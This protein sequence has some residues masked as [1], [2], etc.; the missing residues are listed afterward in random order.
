M[1]ISKIAEKLLE[2]QREIKRL[3]DEVRRFSEEHGGRA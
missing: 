3:R 1:T 2:N